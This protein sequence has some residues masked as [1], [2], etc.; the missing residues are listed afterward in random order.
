MNIR[1]AALFAVLA[2]AAPLSSASAMTVSK[3]QAVATTSSAVVHKAD[4]KRKK[5]RHKRQ[6][7]KA[8]GRYNK[9]PAHWHRYNKRPR[10]W[11]RRGCIIV[12]P[13]WWCP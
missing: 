7:Y 3:P 10:D 6:H 5:Y 1:T 8:G 2:A 13:I 12:G 11:S 4:Y 9:A